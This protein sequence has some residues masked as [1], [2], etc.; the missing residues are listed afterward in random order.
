MKK[1]AVIELMALI[2]RA[3]CAAL[4][5]AVLHEAVIMVHHKVAFN[6]LEGIEDD[7]YENQKRC[8]AEELGEVLADAKESREGGKDS[9]NAEENRSGESDARHNRVEILSG[10]LTG[11][12]T[13]D[14]AIVALHVFSH[15]GGTHCD[16]SVEV[17]EG[18]NEHEVD[19]I[20]PKAIDI[21]EGCIES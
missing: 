21:R 19:K 11:L 3:G 12:Y 10:L 14:E 2:C 13:G 16:G 1:S 9:H 20:I 7:T 17:S 18:Y 8:S 5:L 4:D 15:L 6:L